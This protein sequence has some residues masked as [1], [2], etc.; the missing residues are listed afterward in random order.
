MKKLVFNFSSK[1]SSKL[2]N[3]KNLLGG[4]GAN[5]AEMC[6]LG[7]PVPP[8]FTIST[9]VCEL[10]YKN[11][12]KLNSKIIEEISK[13]LKN[14]EKSSEKKI[15]RFK[16]S[17]ISFSKIWSKSFYARNDGHYFKSWS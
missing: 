9:E 1:E 4:K 6:K 7:L 11:K 8:G 2:K 14:I 15:W 16:K 17:F 13:E 5:L 10:F 3:S 12:K